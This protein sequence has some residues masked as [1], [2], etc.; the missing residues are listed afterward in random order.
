MLIARRVR[1][2]IGVTAIAGCVRDGNGV[3]APIAPSVYLQV[4]SEYGTDTIGIGQHY[5]LRVGAVDGNGRVIALKD[6]M[7]EWFNASFPY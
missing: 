6:A 2:L 1:S 3:T 7:I 5:F 4:S